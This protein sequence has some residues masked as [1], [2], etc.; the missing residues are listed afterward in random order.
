MCLS[1]AYAKCVTAVSSPAS[2]RR[3]G[4][5]TAPLPGRGCVPP[6]ATVS[7]PRHPAPTA[8]PVA[9]PACPAAGT[10]RASAGQSLFSR[11]RRCSAHGRTR[12]A[13]TH[14]ERFRR[15]G[16]AMLH[17]GERSP[18]PCR[19]GKRT[20]DATVVQM[21]PIPGRHAARQIPTAS[22]APPRPLLTPDAP[23]VRVLTV[24]LRPFPSS[25]RVLFVNSLVGSPAG[26]PRP[27]SLR[28]PSFE[29]REGVAG[30]RSSGVEAVGGARGHARVV[31]HH[32]VTCRCFGSGPPERR[33]PRLDFVALANASKS[34][35][36]SARAGV[37]RRQRHDLHGV[38][39]ERRSTPSC[40]SVSA[41]DSA[42]SRSMRQT[43][44]RGRTPEN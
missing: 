22:V 2:R 38:E 34:F 16:S 11:P 18:G 10:G 17:A 44:T 37:P 5:E 14:R 4:P 25:S 13:C 43:G 19:A 6:D 7:G 31:S 28:A 3:R 41:R 42:V 8:A 36:P 1:A 26:R 30:C 12:P 15:S 40:T 32:A 39:A 21:L 29:E 20:V 33:A 24:L 23:C 27:V 35:P 9:V